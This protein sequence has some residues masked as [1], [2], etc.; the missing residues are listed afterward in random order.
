M[1]PVEAHITALLPAS[2]ALAIA[3]TIPLS[4]NEPEGLQPSNLKYNSA[5]P[6]C[7]AK[8][9]TLT[10]GVSPSPMVNI[11][12]LGVIGSN[13]WYLKRTPD[14]AIEFINPPL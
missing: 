14:L 9:S 4:L 11:G 5:Q 1:L 13:F 10:R 3:I 8:A 2:I 6:T 7:R 12:V